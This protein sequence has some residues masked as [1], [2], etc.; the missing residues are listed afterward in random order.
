M[1]PRAHSKKAPRGSGAVRQSKH[2]TGDVRCRST[3]ERRA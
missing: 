3:A 2:S 1:T